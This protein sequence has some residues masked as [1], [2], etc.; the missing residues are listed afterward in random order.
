MSRKETIDLAIPKT[1]YQAYF[2]CQETVKTTEKCF[3][4]AVEKVELSKSK[5]VAVNTILTVVE[6]TVVEFTIVEK[7]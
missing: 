4:Q 1:L 3:R 7:S 2:S 5:L 6:L